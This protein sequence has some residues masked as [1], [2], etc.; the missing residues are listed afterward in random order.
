MQKKDVIL[1]WK[2]RNL[3][4]KGMRVYRS[5]KPF[6]IENAPV[7]IADLPRN[8][9]EYID[10]FQT[11]GDDLYYRVSAWIKGKEVFSKLI[12][13]RV[14][15]PVFIYSGSSDNYMK[16]IH[17]DGYE[18][19][20]IEMESTIVAVETRFN[21]DIAVGFGNTVRLYDQESNLLWEYDFSST[22]RDIT[23][24]YNNNVYVV[25][26]AGV[27]KLTIDGIL[28]WSIPHTTIYSA[29]FHGFLYIGTRNRT[30]ECYDMNGNNIWISDVPTG[31]PYSIFVERSGEIYTG[32]TSGNIYKLDMY[33]HQIWRKSDQG[34]T[35]RGIT[36][37]NVGYL[38]TASTDNTIVKRKAGNGSIVDTYDGH[39]NNINDLV[40][41][42]S[43]FI[44]SASS[45]NSVHCFYPN[46]LKNKWV[47]NGHQSN[48]NAISTAKGLVPLL[49]PYYINISI[50]VPD[51]VVSTLHE[52]LLL[53]SNSQGQYRTD[54]LFS[55][56]I[57]ISITDVG[58]TA[59][60]NIEP[61]I[62]S[63]NS[64]G[65]YSDD[66]LFTPIINVNIFNVMENSTDIIDVKVSA[67]NIQGSYNVN[68]LFAPDMEI[69]SS[70]V[71]SNLGSVFE[72][73]P[74]YINIDI[75]H[76]DY[77]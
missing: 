58:S 50:P 23:C 47:F 54:V 44:Y 40:Q 57:N 41:D 5:N 55:P 28:E 27:H 18:L 70:G 76:G 8:T 34:G 22:V 49:P 71:N 61:I 45:D 12:S 38:F 33:G 1:R 51:N 26:D 15:P 3:I 6:T 10:R 64:Q 39:S 77:K 17:P 14:N 9:S 56:R 29:N 35:I 65:F 46:D 60:Y 68:T 4:E 2:D 37:S 42:S 72:P 32:D 19:W 31:F 67:V 62:I 16:K 24:D 52:P 73:K 7:P 36:L 48:V 43:G 59:E 21:E 69:N 63:V 74:E 66:A 75:D 30:V 20:E 11:V 53:Y 13:I 25:G